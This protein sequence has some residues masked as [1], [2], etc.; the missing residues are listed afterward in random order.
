M[1]TIKDRIR[2]FCDRCNLKVSTF[3][4]TCGFCNGYVNGIRKNVSSEKLSII[5]KKY[6]DLNRNWLVF[7]EGL[8]LKTD[9]PETMQREL[10]GNIKKRLLIFI[11]TYAKMDV[12]S[13]AE[14]FNL[15]RNYFIDREFVEES[16][17]ESI[18]SKYPTLNRQ[19]IN[20]GCGS[21]TSDDTITIYDR[22]KSEFKKHNIDFVKWEVERCGFAQGTFARC[23]GNISQSRLLIIKDALPKE[24][25]KEWILEG[26]NGIKNGAA[27]EPS[28]P[29]LVRMYEHKTANATSQ[30]STPTESVMLRE[31][32]L[33]S[34]GTKGLVIPINLSRNPKAKLSDISSQEIEIGKIMPSFK[35]LYQ[36]Q[37]HQLEPMVS[38]GD[39][40][41]L[42]TITLQE[43][44]NNEIYLVN[45]NT[46][47][48]MVRCFQWVSEGKINL[49]NIDNTAD[50][51]VIEPADINDIC[52]ITSILKN[53][54]SFLPFAQTALGQTMMHRDK[55]MEKQME[56]SRDMFEEL[57]KNNQRTD[58]LIN[59]LTQKI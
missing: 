48:V 55:L 52:A 20:Y 53:C 14:Q 6:P 41:M 43:V 8:M 18:Y 57:K 54:T 37:T 17:W 36:V 33:I 7:G 39:W 9:T 42:D 49:I 38:Q 59:L 21:M 5:L 22:I 26:E 51:L 35:F 56:F 29:Y 50:V 16:V 44:V 1:N 4:K 46:Y 28:V 45:T 58:T 47:G 40:L 13:F 15:D 11:A 30:E 2:I 3:E 19:W 34:E 12:L 25:D 10:L 23:K 31:T 24:V 27:A 32:H